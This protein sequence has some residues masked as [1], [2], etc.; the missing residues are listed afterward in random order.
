MKDPTLQDAGSQS[1][2]QQR[3]FSPVRQVR[4]MPGKHRSSDLDFAGLTPVQAMKSAANG[5]PQSSIRYE[6]IV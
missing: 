2:N 6:E 3:Y 4:R 1:E 5:A